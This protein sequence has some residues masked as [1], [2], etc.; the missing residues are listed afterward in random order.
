M[1]FNSFPRDGGDIVEIEENGRIVPSKGRNY[2]FTKELIA[3]IDVAIG[4]GRPLLV[5]GEPGC[6]KTELGYAIARRMGIPRV[7]FF[8]TKSNAEA[9]DLFYSYDA[10]GRFREA[11][12]VRDAGDPQS[13]VADY[14]EFQALGK[15]ILDAH[16][17]QD[18]EHLLNPRGAYK[19]PGEPSR[20][21]VILDEIDKASRDFPN[22]LLREVEDLAFRVPELSRRGS[23]R[24]DPETPG[25]IPAD[26]RPIV[27]VTS[28]EERQLP[29]AFL[30]RCV[31]HE[32]AFPDDTTLSKIVASGLR[33]RLP[34]KNPEDP[35]DPTG[36][37]LPPDDGLALLKLLAEFRDLRLDK[38]PGISEAIDAAALLAYPRSLPSPSLAER[39]PLIAPALAKL[40]NDRNLL[41]GL[42]DSA[43]GRL[44]TAG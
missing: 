3:A 37:D 18:V 44:G 5:S 17:K 12:T 20:S 24:A 19:H 40:R 22:D 2:I 31:F 23:D 41:A 16:D 9:R 42:I 14:I 11:Q 34:S 39:L 35:N 30:R 13:D 29:D 7:H 6:G 28:N 25:G 36:Y 21:V 32:I 33:K 8:S 15:A 26:K 10:I 27:V 4:L 43:I 38:R 1:W